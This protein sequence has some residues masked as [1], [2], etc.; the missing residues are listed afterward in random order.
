MKQK[1]VIRYSEAF[2]RQVVDEIEKGD[3][4]LHSIQK[5]YGIGGSYLNSISKCNF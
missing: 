5:K 2:K 1:K 4:S 3:S